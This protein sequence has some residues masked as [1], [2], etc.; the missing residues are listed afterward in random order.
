M[1]KVLSIFL[2][3]SFLKDERNRSLYAKY[4]KE[5]PD[6]EV[7]IYDFVLLFAEYGSCCDLWF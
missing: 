7:R 5:N 4:I 1:S 3:L 2:R 6:P